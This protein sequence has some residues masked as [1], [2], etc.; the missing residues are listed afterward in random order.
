ML[1]NARTAK[2]IK[3]IGVSV[4]GQILSIVIAFITRTY[5]IRLLGQEFLGINGL[6]I[7]IVSFLA[8][9]ELGFGAA[10]TFSLYKPLAE[11]DTERIKSLMNLFRKIY[12]IIGFAIIVLGLL[13]MP[14][15][16]Y[17]TR[18]V[19]GIG[20]LYIYFLLFLLNSAFSYFYSYKGTLIIADQKGYVIETYRYI[21]FTLY[22]LAQLAILILTQN[23]YLFLV[24]QLA[25]TIVRNFMINYKANKLFPLLKE[26]NINKLSAEDS[27][28][29]KKNIRAMLYQRLGAV[30]NTTLKAPIISGIVSIVVLGIY[31]NYQL[32]TDS[33]IKIIAIIF[34]SLTAS[35]GNL[36]A[37]SDKVKSEKIFKNI[38]FANYWIIAFSS[39]MLIALFNPFI[40]LWAGEDYLLSFGVVLFIVLN[41]YLFG[42]RKAVMSFKTAFGLFWY[43][44]Y[45]P[46]LEAI[47][48]IAL[49]II[50]GNRI[51]LIGI[52]IGNS[53]TNIISLCI[54]PYV[55][56]RY[57]FEMKNRSFYL[58]YLLYF[59][60][61][62]VVGIVIYYLNSLLVDGAVWRFILR[63][64][65]NL[66]VINLVF[67]LLFRKTTNYNYF[68]KTVVNVLRQFKIKSFKT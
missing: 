52:F 63:F 27:T 53:M 54:E 67:Y 66:V 34:T 55:L 18:D 40:R 13:F 14:F 23:Y 29:L 35:V 44:R 15:L 62:I 30:F 24:A 5:F 37:T 57:G 11:E 61:T 36:G 7:S 2:S 8:V 21:I 49:M 46:F 16:H 17:F 20:N 10:I 59:G 39:L 9:A 38:F 25:G 3:N 51:G 60:L 58:K 42:M 64:F 68:K 56:Y 19:A 12:I 22:N 4:V 32:I 1:T 45:R 31:T 28:S 26:K 50:L 43:D 33:L 6:F 65:F 41:F 47:A 48:G